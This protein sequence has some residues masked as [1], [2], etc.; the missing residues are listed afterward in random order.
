MS[1]VDS[2]QVLQDAGRLG[3]DDVHGCGDD[4]GQRVPE[5]DDPLR[6]F[7]DLGEDH[8]QHERALVVEAFPHLRAADVVLHGCLDES[9]D[10]IEDDED[11]DD[12]EGRDLR[13]LHVFPFLVG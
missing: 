9:R 10:V 5:V 8:D 3:Q 7:Q 4:D 6:V 12:G 13:L 2:A 11:T 1:S